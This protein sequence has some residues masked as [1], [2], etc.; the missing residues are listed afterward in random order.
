MSVPS[1]YSIEDLIAEPDAWDH[2]LCEF[3]GIAP[4]GMTTQRSAPP[5]RVLPDEINNWEELVQ[6]FCD[7]PWH[8]FFAVPY[9]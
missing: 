7:T 3:L 2:R 4:S 8:D 1:L 6:R 5:V 9:R